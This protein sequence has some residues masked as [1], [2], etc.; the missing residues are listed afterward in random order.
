MQCLTS[1][2]HVQDF[3]CR[4]K[5][6]QQHLQ[7]NL[8][9]DEN[10]YYNVGRSNAHKCD[11]NDVDDYAYVST[12]AVTRPYPGTEESRP[13]YHGL[14]K[15]ESQP[16]KGTHKEIEYEI[17]AEPRAFEQNNNNRHKKINE[18]SQPDRVNNK[19]AVY[20]QVQKPPKHREE[21]DDKSYYNTAEV[22]QKAQGSK[23]KRNV[24]R[25]SF[26]GERPTSALVMVDNDL[27]AGGP[28]PESELHMVDNE[29]YALYKDK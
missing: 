17:M 2:I 8:P 26:E 29:L 12:H 18:L 10:E 6:N 13:G 25:K 28:R 24:H 15:E 14:L 3:F 23:E 4:K 22:L 19:H 9:A 20:S 21:K 11:D 1:F 16:L 27:Y 7:R 5:H